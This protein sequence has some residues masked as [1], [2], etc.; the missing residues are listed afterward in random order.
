[1]TKVVAGRRSV[2]VQWELDESVDARAASTYYIKYRR[3]GKRRYTKVLFLK[4]WDVK[5]SLY[6]GIVSE[7]LGC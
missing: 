6:Q 1:M 7:E 2:T 5:M 3:V 4:N